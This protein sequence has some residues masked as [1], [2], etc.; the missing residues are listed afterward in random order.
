M[1]KI[2][3]HIGCSGF[4]YKEWKEEF[5]PKG[6]AQ[7]KWFAYYTEHFNT[8]EL[9]VT[10]YRF[11]TL[12]SLEGWYAKAPDGFS[13]SAKVPRTITHYKKFAETESM[14]VDFYAT[15]REG[16]KEK[17][18]CVLF[19]LPPSFAYNEEKLEK[20]LEH[21]DPS[22]Q[23]VIEFRHESWWREDVKQTLAKHQISFCGVSFPKISFDDAVINI[24]LTYY[25]FHG[26][27]VLFHS[28]YDPAFI[29]KIY[30]QIATEKKVKEA[31]IC[32]NNTASLAALHNAKYFQQLVAAEV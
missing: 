12:K 20:I 31:F 30:Q 32:F 14:M 16:L 29:D 22:F 5:Y 2:R 7:S 1:Q 24:P 18:S 21:T 4:S 11:P 26:V 10:F 23:N 15:L 6:L 25:R 28:E 27:P 13:F 9:N 19:Q 3:W 17:L 8:L